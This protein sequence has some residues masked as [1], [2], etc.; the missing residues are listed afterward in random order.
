MCTAAA[1]GGV[2]EKNNRDSA[3]ILS[4]RVRVI[5]C[6]LLLVIPNAAV[7]AVSM[8]VV[9]DMSIHNR[10]VLWQSVCEMCADSPL[11]G[12]GRSV[13]DVYMA[14][15]QPLERMQRYSTAVNDYLTI[16]ARYGMIV[17]MLWMFVIILVASGLL[18]TAR[19]KCS[20]VMAALAAGVFSY[21]TAAMFSTFYTTPFLSISFTVALLLGVFLIVRNGLCAGCDH[22][23]KA[24]FMA[25]A[26][27]VSIL[28]FGMLSRADDRLRYS[29]FCI[30]GID[31][32]MVRKGVDE[33]SSVVIFLFDKKEASL[34]FEGRRSVRNLVGDGRPVIA[35]GITSDMNGYECARRFVCD[36][37]VRYGRNMPLTLVGQNCGGRFAIL[38][39]LELDG[40]R[41]VASIGAYAT[42]PMADLSPSD[43]QKVKNRPEM[44]IINGDADWHTDVSN[45]TALKEICGRLGIPCRAS[46]IPDV[47]NSL[48]KRRQPIME[49]I[50]R[51][52]SE[53]D[54]YLNG[55]GA[56]TI[57]S[58]TSYAVVIIALFYC[59]ASVSTD[60]SQKCRASGW[61][62]QCSDASL[63]CE[64]CR[65]YAAYVYE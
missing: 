3:V 24:L 18:R 11:F 46:V 22:V 37:W 6:A 28:V 65:G 16:G 58:A 1:V 63:G 60:G 9:H 2:A 13:G 55:I 14:W 7:R 42:W 54:G 5:I 31:S 50:G 23:M 25:L 62:C 36:A 35:A 15:R 57:Q 34:E 56:L 38:L 4:R 20:P 29:Y 44:W 8:D 41:K 19:V 47:G 10:I 45:V 64:L 12:I 49:D 53:E 33:V 51:W 48:G 39:G 21:A 61:Y 59:F 30:N 43:C 27:C 40:V 32:V 52:L 17:L 26:V